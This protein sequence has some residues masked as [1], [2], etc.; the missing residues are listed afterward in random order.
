M[1]KRTM[2]KEKYILDSIRNS[3][4]NLTP[5]IYN[6]VMEEELT[7]SYNET[8]YEGTYVRSKK[9]MFKITAAAAAFLVICFA[10]YMMVNFIGLI[11]PASRMI[12]RTV[13]YTEKYPQITNERAP[14]INEAADTLIRL[15]DDFL[16]LYILD[17]I[18][19]NEYLREIDMIKSLDLSIVTEDQIID[20]IA[21]QMHS[22]VK[23]INREVNKTCDSEKTIEEKI[24]ELSRYGALCVPVL[25]WRI[26]VGETEYKQYIEE[27]ILDQSGY[28]KLDELIQAIESPEVGFNYGTDN[29]EILTDIRTTYGEDI[30]NEFL[31][32]NVR[33][34]SDLQS[35]SNC[36]SA[37]ATS[38]KLKEIKMNRFL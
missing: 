22:T 5:D 3:I 33:T 26:E 14:L 31:F 7:I 16:T 17:F 6:K 10:S 8:Q 27:Y 28:K 30:V 18:D 23:Y 38:E 20:Y 35:I 21:N 29:N 4:V 9:S 13:P 2:N 15:N 11:A 36:E 1:N 32:N 19:Y 37:K 24:K 25:A 34:I 12:D